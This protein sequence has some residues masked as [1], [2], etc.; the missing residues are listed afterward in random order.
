MKFGPRPPGS[1]LLAPGVWLVCPFSFPQ[2]APDIVAGNAKGVR[3]VNYTHLSYQPY[4]LPQLGVLSTEETHSDSLSYNQPDSGSSKGPSGQAAKP[5]H[6]GAGAG[7]ADC[8]RM[9]EIRH[10]NIQGTPIDGA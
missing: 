4:D 8:R 7:A 9:V 5:Q 2:L 6:A 10:G 3:A 1:A